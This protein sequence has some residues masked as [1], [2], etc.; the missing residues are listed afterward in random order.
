M[1]TRKKT[2]KNLPKQV[3]IFSRSEINSVKV[4]RQLREQHR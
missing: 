2:K 4:Q 1:L 3:F